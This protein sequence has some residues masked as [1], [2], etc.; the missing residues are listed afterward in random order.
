MKTTILGTIF[1]TF[2]MLS[3]CFISPIQVKA[4]EAD[5]KQ[6]KNDIGNLAA[7]LSEHEQFQEII[8]NENLLAIINDVIENGAT[9]E[10][11]EEYYNIIKDLD[12][13]NEIC[14]DEILSYA[15][16]IYSA[17]DE[18]LTKKPSTFSNE[19][20]GFYFKLE[21]DNT[22]TI[23][24]GKI[25]N[26]VYVN[27]EKDITIPG[28]ATVEFEATQNILELI[29]YLFLAGIAGAV[30]VAVVVGVFMLFE[31]IFVAIGAFF[32]AIA[33]SLLTVVII[34]GVIAGASMVIGWIIYVI[35]ELLGSDDK[36]KSK[37][38]E[39]RLQKISYK[40]QKMISKI[41]AY[42]NMKIQNIFS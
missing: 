18:I 14:T 42:L 17:V 37:Q 6:T 24:E 9:Q 4:A 25:E 22:I 28:Y 1:A 32:G 21:N 15:E 39:L 10:K 5:I 23:S 29:V 19:E 12:A 34:F 7:L 20:K 38:K 11:S 33:G 41:F 30:A 8:E 16:S 2:L 26:S 36:S 27:S 40:I 3:I 31:A 35:Q 13:F